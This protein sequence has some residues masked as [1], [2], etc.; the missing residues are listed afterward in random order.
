MTAARRCSNWREPTRDR[1]VTFAATHECGNMGKI[2]DPA[3]LRAGRFDRQLL[4]GRP[5]KAGRIEILKVHSKKLKAGRE[6][7]ETARHKALHILA[8]LP[9]GAGRRRPL[10]AGE[11][12]PCSKTS[13]RNRISVSWRTSKNYSQS[14]VSWSLLSFAT[15]STMPNRI[16][17]T[18]WTG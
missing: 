6:L 9:Q 5:D 1:E 3:F 10:P 7:S 4:V 2:L 14:T 12:E 13:C 15:H 18:A 11:R 16:G 8:D 17:V